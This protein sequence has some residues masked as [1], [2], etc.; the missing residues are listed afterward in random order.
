MNCLNC[1]KGQPKLWGNDGQWCNT[2]CYDKW[3]MKEADKEMVDGVV[4]KHK[5]DGRVETNEPNRR[6][7]D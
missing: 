2:D 4:K 3:L 1:G 7:A 5:R 6:E